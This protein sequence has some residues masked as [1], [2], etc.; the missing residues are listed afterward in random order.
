MPVIQDAPPG[1]LP[2]VQ[3][4]LVGRGLELRRARELLAS[5]RL[6]TLVGPGGVGKTRL[7][8]RLAEEVGGN[9]ADGVC[10]VELKAV[11]DERLVPLA[12]ASALGITLADED[13]T[14]G[15]AR[16]LADKHLLL[17]LDNCEHLAAAARGLLEVVL[18]AAPRVK[19]VTSSRH[20]LDVPGEQL[21]IVPTLSVPLNSDPSGLVA[22]ASDAVDLFLDRVHEVQP[23][24]RI[25]EDN[26]DA[27][28]ALCRRLDGMPLAL[29]L[30]ASW[31]RGMTVTDV[32][33]DLDSRLDMAFADDGPNGAGRTL[34][35]TVRASHELCLP[36]ER[37]LWAR[38]SVFAGPFDLSAAESVCSDGELPKG[39]V[40]ETVDGLLRQSVVRRV[41]ELSAERAYYDMPV[42]IRLYGE[43]RLRESGQL[44]L[45]QERHADYY[46]ALA[47]QAGAGFFGPRQE[48]WLLRIRRELDE[49]RAAIDYYLGA[50]DRPETALRLI[51]AL[52][53]YW[54]V[55]SAREGYDLLQRA[56]ARVPEPSLTRATGLWAA[57]HTAMYVNEVA[58]GKRALEES[59][60]LAERLGDPTLSARVL[61][62]EGEALFCDQ[63]VAGCLETWQRA[64][65]AFRE[66]GDQYGE[67]QVLMTSSAASFFSG[68]PRL[69]EFAAGALAL[70]EGRGAESSGA[71]AVYAMGNA[72]LLA[73]RP[74]E[75]IDCYQEAVRRWE[76]SMYLSG[77]AFA[78]EG[79]AWAA[80]AM[81]P[82][83]HA[84]RLLG[85][86]SAVWRRSG[87]QVDQ[88][89]F[90]LA[91]DLQ[92]REAVLAALGQERFEDA[93]AQG[94]RLAMDEALALAKSYR[95]PASGSGGSPDS[96][97]IGPLSRRESEVAELVAQGLTNQQIAERLLI[98]HR[99]VETHVASIYVKLGVTSRSA[100]A[101]WMV[102]HSE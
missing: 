23:T 53:D 66:V 5:S 90:Y 33:N 94:A 62:V 28:A 49:L 29:E 1:V 18:G 97:R 74:E 61:Q 70:A 21:L 75:A 80:E 31:L 88:L 73:G 46:A 82:D 87:M 98:S 39:S 32:V 63:D 68:D 95:N 76:P 10:W 27:V 101:A 52:A 17:V 64:A 92:A 3:T 4:R 100:V 81:K 91:R 77:L 8:L 50:V 60:E 16:Y 102:R 45:W 47:E 35:S 55:A 84:A 22:G 43:S 34:E 42:T 69:E 11:R 99:T 40:L 44:P 51:T 24:F 37:T 13:T 20:V 89:P 38:L 56:L 2:T 9:F 41:P 26:G 96:R 83:R 78:V 71:A 59:R 79:I 65:G 54:F 12:V 57:A 72:H 85:A 15:L 67:F 93:L 48:Q 14:A 86:S 7:S 25:T 30:A 58:E 19:A 36:A 6:L